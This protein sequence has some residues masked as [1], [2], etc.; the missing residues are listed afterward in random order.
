M[1][2]TSSGATHHDTQAEADVHMSEVGCARHQG[3]TA[4]W[5]STG[6][7]KQNLMEKYG[8]LTSPG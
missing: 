8:Q 2:T 4:K 6:M 1:A 3:E 5:Q 7:Q